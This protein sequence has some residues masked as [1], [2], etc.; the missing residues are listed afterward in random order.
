MTIASTPILGSDPFSVS[1]TQ[2]HALGT[3]AVIQIKDS[4]GNPAFCEAVYCKSLATLSANYLTEIPLVRGT[5]AFQID[6]HVTTTTA[7]AIADTVGDKFLAG[8]PLVASVSGDYLWVAVKGLV[9][10]FLTA[11]C[12]V[13]AVVHTT[14]T[15]GLLD[16]AVTTHRVNGVAPLATVGGSNAVTDCYIFSDISVEKIS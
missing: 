2:E 10:V 9:P 4:S 12:A 16:D 15:A 3:R 14:A 5:D 13:G 8:V 11:A 6:A 7:A 1:T